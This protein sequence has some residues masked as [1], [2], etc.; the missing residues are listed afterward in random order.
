METMSRPQQQQPGSKPAVAPAKEQPIRDGGTEDLMVQGKGG[1]LPL[2][3][4]EQPHYYS[5]SKKRK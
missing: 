4:A 3:G 5:D 2:K 1:T